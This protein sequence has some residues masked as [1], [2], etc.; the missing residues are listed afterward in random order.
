MTVMQF[1]RSKMPPHGWQAHET[2]EIVRACAE[3][4]ASGKASGWEIGETEAGDPQ[5]Y[6]LGPAPDFDCILCVSRLGGLYV[7]EDG[8]GR[9]LFEHPN[10]M[11]LAEQAS[12]AVRRR[13]AAMVAKLVLIWGAVRETFEEKIEPF[14]AEPIELVTHVAPQIA[15]FA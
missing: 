15:G 6:L 8:S 3:T 10:L 13:K 14:L 7:L 5:L 4:L 9:I 2:Q 12:A 11:L 1:P